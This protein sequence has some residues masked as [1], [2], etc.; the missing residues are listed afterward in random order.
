M[1][2]PPGTLD[3]TTITPGPPTGAG[4]AIDPSHWVAAELV[5]GS[6]TQLTGLELAVSRDEPRGSP[7]G[8]HGSSRRRPGR[9]GGVGDLAVSLWNATAAGLPGSEI[10]STTVS[11]V[12][13]GSCAAGHLTEVDLFNPPGVT[14]GQKVFVVLGG[15]GGGG[16]GGVRSTPSSTIASSNGIS[17]NTAGPY[18]NAGSGWFEWCAYRGTV[19]QVRAFSGNQGS[20]WGSVTATASPSGLQPLWQGTGASTGDPALG[21]ADY[22]T[23]GPP[24]VTPEAPLSALLPV[25]GAGTIG[26]VLLVRRRRGSIRST[27]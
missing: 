19:P 12:A 1:A 9:G 5:V 6:G 4:I 8:G 25:I 17:S 16:S 15:L 2:T 21:V 11:R 26:T 20:T 13:G 24:S 3:A 22:V 27:P 7:L 18:G 10:E 23:S 14:P